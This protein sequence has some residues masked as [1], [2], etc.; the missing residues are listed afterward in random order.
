MP[1]FLIRRLLLWLSPW[2]SDPRPESSFR[3]DIEGLR[4]VAILLVVAFHVGIPAL[5]GGFI[6][7]DVFFVISGYLIIGLLVREVE[8][9]G[10]LNFLGFYARRA[11]RLLPASALTLIVTVIVASLLFTPLERLTFARTASA[12]ALYSAISGSNDRH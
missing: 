12:A 3:P 4:A 5:Q 11:R 2:R 9:T 7:V 10:R 1:A 6:G 8:N